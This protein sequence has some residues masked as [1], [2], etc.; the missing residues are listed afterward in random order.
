[1]HF[2]KNALNKFLLILLCLFLGCGDK[3]NQKK[4]LPQITDDWFSFAGKYARKPITIRTNKR[5][6]SVVGH[7]DLQHQVGI[8]V[9]ILDPTKDGFPNAEE[10]VKLKKI[11]NILVSELKES[12]LA[13]FAC[14]ITT[15][16]IREF[17]FYTGNPKE[18]ENSFKRIEESI[19][20]HTV[21]LNIQKDKKWM[22]Y[23]IFS[24]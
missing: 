1:M 20:T 22:V 8:A 19:S 21:Q 10:E 6:K 2:L 14:V 17:I 9:P 18:A 5:L 16:G 7:K 23:K 12:G 13:V 3:S 11:E 15:N 24:D 4:A